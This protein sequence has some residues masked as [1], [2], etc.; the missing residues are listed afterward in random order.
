MVE[1]ETS[2][3]KAIQHCE[4]SMAIAEPPVF[5]ERL[6]LKIKTE[7]SPLDTALSSSM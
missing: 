5:V 2:M 4:E 1:E 6:H 3:P 7:V